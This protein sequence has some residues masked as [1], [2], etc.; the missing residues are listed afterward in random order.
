[1]NPEWDCLQANH[2]STSSETDNL[3]CFYRFRPWTTFNRLDIT[4]Y[5]QRLSQAPCTSVPVTVGAPFTVYD[6]DTAPPYS[7]GPGTV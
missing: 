3:F 5:F 7:A 4:A 6:I 2:M 1:M